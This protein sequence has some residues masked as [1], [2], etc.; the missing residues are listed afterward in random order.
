MDV[1]DAVSLSMDVQEVRLWK[2]E[3][4]FDG[5]QHFISDHRWGLDGAGRYHATSSFLIQNLV[6]QPTHKSDTILIAPS[7]AVAFVRWPKPCLQTYRAALNCRLPTPL[8]SQTVTIFRAISMS[9][10]YPKLHVSTVIS[11]FFIVALLLSNLGGLKNMRM[12][13]KSIGKHVFI[14]IA[15]FYQRQS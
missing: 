15:D 10:L 6:P 4:V 3:R 8:H 13:G 2:E 12:S 7:C 5:N 1:L 11:P 9:V 14:Y